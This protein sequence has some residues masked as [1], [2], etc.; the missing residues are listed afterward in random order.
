M[1]YL[2]VLNNNLNII[3][4]LK[5]KFNQNDVNL[6]ELSDDYINYLVNLNDEDKMVN[7]LKII[8]LNNS[9]C[10]KSIISSNEFR[11]MISNLDK[12]EDIEF[13]KL[14]LEDLK[15][16][17]KV[18]L[19]LL[20]KY[21]IKDLQY[22]SKVLLDKINS[23]YKTSD[24]GICFSIIIE[25]LSEKS[26]YLECKEDVLYSIINLA[27]ISFNSYEDNISETK[28]LVGY[29]LENEIFN[30]HYSAIK[31]L[32]CK[33]L[34]CE[35][36]NY[37]KFLNKYNLDDF[38]MDSLEK[39]NIGKRLDLLKEIS[40]NMDDNSFNWFL[41]HSDDDFLTD[42]EVNTVNY[43]LKCGEKLVLKDE[44]DLNYNLFLILKFI[45]PNFNESYINNLNLL[46]LYHWVL[47][48]G[49]KKFLE[50]I[51]NLGI[52]KYI[53]KNSLIIMPSVYKTLNLNSLTEE[54]IIYLLEHKEISYRVIL[55]SLEYKNQSNMSFKEFQMIL[56]MSY[57]VFDLY[58]QM[59]DLKLD[60]RIRLIK[61]IPKDISGLDCKKI[62][63]LIKEK[64]LSDRINDMY[65]N[66][67]KEKTKILTKKDWLKF[68]IIDDLDNLKAQVKSELDILF[69][70]NYKEEIKKSNTG[71]L[72][73]LKSYVFKNSSKYR[74][75]VKQLNLSEDFIKENEEKIQEF[76]MNGNIDIY[77]SYLESV[78]Y[79]YKPNLNNIT[80]AELAGRLEDV[81][82]HKGDLS[83]EIEY[84]VPFDIEEMWKKNISLTTKNY[85]I[86]EAYDYNT[87]MQIGE[88][89][90]RTCM[91]YKSGM[92]ND[93]LLSNFD[94]NKKILVVKNEF[95]NIVARAILRFTKI[96]NKKI[97][98]S[99]TDLS[100]IDIENLNK[101][102]VKSKNEPNEE[103]VVFL[104][105][106]YTSLNEVSQVKLD[107]VKFAYKKAKELGVRLIV[108]D[109]YTSSSL[110]KIRK[111]MPSLQ[112]KSKGYIYISKS[113]N[114]YQY[115]DSF[116]GSYKNDESE[117][118]KVD[119]YT[120]FLQE[121][122]FNPLYEETE[123]LEEQILLY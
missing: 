65:K 11:A 79:K 56:K 37:L 72:E 69:L 108:S 60:E 117:Y 63:N 103:L 67:I 95:G 43:K 48:K 101:E 2:N 109:G 90:V 3:K 111:Y 31:K 97:E 36:M 46:R 23:Y 113:K 44:N 107:M 99:N 62:V 88:K 71:N 49:K 54:E 41:H 115:L 38:N 105:R 89:P 61:D 98:K 1:S 93:A 78:N 96:S 76:F 39:H 27:T 87:V 15:I 18:D 116:G 123:Y 81:K 85:D 22:I 84:E 53:N 10:T 13:I 25:V 33:K 106:C 77:I 110:S 75:L 121:N 100:F 5:T 59:F 17:N 29:A 51:K 45:Y 6:L 30:F 19:N 64:G 102:L 21:R 26:L 57:D 8:N 68:F 58:S 4:V 91:S 52:N 86:R 24:I 73:L 50:K 104:E 120:V 74:K 118:V 32:N 66:L 12:K 122:M 112:A 114:G 47:Q 14:L 28:S 35:Q 7:L 34:N 94:A 80:K 9:Q 20:A 42:K 70:I 119:N 55:K 16:Y 40:T 82:F 92:Y 83:K